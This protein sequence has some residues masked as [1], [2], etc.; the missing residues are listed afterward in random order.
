MDELLYIR[1]PNL[2][3]AVSLSGV[4]NLDSFFPKKN[5]AVEYC[6]TAL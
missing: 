4:F 3:D 6:F 2:I 5:R 1:K